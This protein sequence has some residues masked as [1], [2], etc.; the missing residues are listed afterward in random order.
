MPFCTVDFKAYQGTTVYCCEEV[1]PQSWL[2][3][4][5][6]YRITVSISLINVL[7]LS[8]SFLTVHVFPS[9]PSFLVR[10]GAY[11]E[12]SSMDS[13]A[14]AKHPL[15]QDPIVDQY[16]LSSVRTVAVGGG[17]LSE[18]VATRLEQRFGFGIL[19][20]YGLSET[21]GVITAADVQTK[22][23]RGTVGRLLPN[24][25]AKLV[26][27]ELLLKGPNITKG[28]FKNPKK[29][30]ELFTEDGWM[31]TGDACEIDEDGYLSVIGRMEDVSCFGYGYSL[32]SLMPVC[33]AHLLQRNQSEL[34]CLLFQDEFFI[35]R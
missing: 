13:S 27:G 22:E 7:K 24:M 29:T 21:T 20:G 33:I 34:F 5:Q 26:G 32:P 25:I 23:K 28:Y 19:A 16:D 1:T 9:I 6:K 15:F 11:Y 17:A 30:S 12:V 18:Y 8:L 2:G 31:K 4:I 10:Q 35:M 3:T 14:P